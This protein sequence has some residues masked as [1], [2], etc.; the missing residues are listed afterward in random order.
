MRVIPAAL[1]LL[2]TACTSPLTGPANPTRLPLEDGIRHVACALEVVL[3]GE[4]IPPGQEMSCIVDTTAA[5]QRWLVSRP[6]TWAIEFDL[7]DAGPGGARLSYNAWNDGAWLDLDGEIT[8]EAKAVR[9]AAQTSGR[10]VR[11]LISVE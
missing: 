6:D 4:T 5:R 11:A 3:G 7:T 10:D 8:V 9:I 1:L 2:L